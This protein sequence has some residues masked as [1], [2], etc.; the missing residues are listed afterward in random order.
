MCSAVGRR[1]PDADSLAKKLEA[2]TA[3]DSG[4]G[5]GKVKP[6]TFEDCARA[7]GWGRWTGEATV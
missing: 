2:Q 7:E 4:V 3:F 5:E 1:T 6:R